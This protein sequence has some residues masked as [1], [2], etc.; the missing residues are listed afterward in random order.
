MLDYTDLIAK[1][2]EAAGSAAGDIRELVVNEVISKSAG[3]EV[4]TVIV[5]RVVSNELSTLSE[6]IFKETIPQLIIQSALVK[7]GIIE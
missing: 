4:A 5:T 1:I 6:G 3:T 7:A 2:V